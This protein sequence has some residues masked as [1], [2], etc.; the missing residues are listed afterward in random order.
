LIEGCLED[1]IAFLNELT[2]G[3]RPGKKACR[4]FALPVSMVDK[5]KT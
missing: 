3:I 4:A 1:E 2:F 5:E